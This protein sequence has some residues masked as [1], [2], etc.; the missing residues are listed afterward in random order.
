MIKARPAERGLPIV[1]D[2]GFNKLVSLNFLN[3]RGAVSRPRSEPAG[4]LG[5]L[6]SWFSD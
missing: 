3:R 6:C 2:H 1:A 5:P 4:L